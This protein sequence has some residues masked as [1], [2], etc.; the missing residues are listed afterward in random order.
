M[1]SLLGEDNDDMLYG[2][3]IHPAL[4]YLHTKEGSEEGKAHQFRVSGLIVLSL[5]L[6]FHQ[7]LQLAFSSR[8]PFE[9]SFFIFVML[10]QLAHTSSSAQSCER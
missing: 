10:L 6:C 1:L 8:M 5:F 9:T 4:S 7:V 2:I 3:F